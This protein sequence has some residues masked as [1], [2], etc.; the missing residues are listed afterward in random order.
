MFDSVRPMLQL[1]GFQ[2]KIVKISSLIAGLAVSAVSLYAEPAF[3]PASAVTQS[4]STLDNGIRVVSIYFPGSTNVSIITFLPLGLAN[5]GPNQT[6]WSHLVEH[7]VIRSTVP[8]D[9]SMANGQTQSAFMHLDFYG[10]I[11]NWK[12]G[13]SHHKRWLEGV[14]FTQA[15]LEAE[16]PKVKA[17]GAF[18]AQHF[19]TSL[20]ALAAWSQGFRHDQTNAFLLRDIDRAS[21]NDIQKYRDS[22][23]A[24]LTNVV[25]CV[26]GGVEP[27]EVRRVVA[28]QL[29]AIKSSA[30]P[31]GQV[32]L[33]PGNREMTWDLNARNLIIT[34]PIPTA[35]G[36][37]YPALS[38]AAHWLTMQFSADA[39]IQQTTG[40]AS[41]DA[42][43]T[44]PEG[45]FF[46]VSA[47][48]RPGSSFNAVQ[49]QMLRYVRSLSSPEQEM[50]WVPM[51]RQQQ[52]ESLTKLTDPASMKAQ[53]P[54]DMTPDMAEG[55]IGLQWGMF[56]FLYGAYK[57][58]LAR[59]LSE[60]KEE[61]I[62][63][64]ARKYLSGSNCS[65]TI[66]RPLTR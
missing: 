30:Q 22:R 58:V 50:S 11:G 40:M 5:D 62:R 64:A 35:E 29:G 41:A 48:L 42:D 60:V 46:C 65:T 47:S 55:N 20:F 34:W 27:A 7:L 15:N 21:L 16:K 18:T 26:V 37:D 10:N 45:N 19:T 39:D 53:L 49:E 24:V 43:L 57:P 12:Q 8:E 66:L 54:P 4:S 36:E 56:E 52:A 32:K 2:M 1:Q 23:L 6:Q 33:H 61:D 51:F 38:V 17:E 3:P 59:R 28:G 44:T 9:L 25:V 63:W 31:V 14:P 13:L